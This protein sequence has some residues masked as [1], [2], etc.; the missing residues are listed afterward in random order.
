[1][2]PTDIDNQ[3]STAR[4]VN[5]AFWAL[6]PELPRQLITYGDGVTMYPAKTINAFAEF[7]DNLVQQG[8]I[9]AELA[10]RVYLTVERKKCHH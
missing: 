3:L 9:T 6:N 8:A 10:G 1:M 4:E 7:V 5:T 2:L